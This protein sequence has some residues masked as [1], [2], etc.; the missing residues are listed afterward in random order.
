MDPVGKLLYSPSCTIFTKPLYEYTATIQYWLWNIISIAV[1][2]TY[3]HRIMIKSAVMH[4][5]FP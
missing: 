1:V 2:I 3:L 4:V 5:Q